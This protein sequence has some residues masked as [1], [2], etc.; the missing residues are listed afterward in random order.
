[1]D[2]GTNVFSVCLSAGLLLYP[3]DERVKMNASIQR[4]AVPARILPN[5]I[6]DRYRPD[7]IHV[8]PIT[9]QYGFN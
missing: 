3:E 5:S 8:G 2:G 6:P 1:M 7:M 9:V 4:N